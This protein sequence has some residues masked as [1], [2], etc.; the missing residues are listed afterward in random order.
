MRVRRRR[1]GLQARFPRG[2]GQ[3]RRWFASA[4]ATRRYAV[5]EVNQR[6]KLSVFY[7]ASR[8]DACAY[9]GTCAG[10]LV[11]LHVPTDDFSYGTAAASMEA[12]RIFVTSSGGMGTPFARAAVHYDFKR[13]NDG[14]LLS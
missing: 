2:S 14:A 12:N 1:S 3:P 6:A 11:K 8:T 5:G 13:P 4:N 7:G 9:S 10:P